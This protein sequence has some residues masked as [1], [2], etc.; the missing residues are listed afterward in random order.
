MK[1]GARGRNRRR[2]SWSSQGSR[3]GLGVGAEGV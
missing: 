1:E 3:K 2:M